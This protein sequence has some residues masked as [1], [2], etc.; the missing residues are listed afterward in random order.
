MV[1][2]IVVEVSYEMTGNGCSYKGNSEVV[3]SLQKKAAP[4]VR[5]RF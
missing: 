2:V 5:S 4:G 3:I 1:L